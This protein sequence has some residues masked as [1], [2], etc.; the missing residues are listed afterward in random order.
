M[1]LPLRSGTHAARL[2]RPHK[3]GVRYQETDSG[4]IYYDNGTSWSLEKPSGLVVKTGDEGIGPSFGQAGGSNTLQNDDHLKFPVEAS[5]R[6]AF[7]LVLDWLTASNVSDLKVGWS[8]PTG[9]S[10]KWA[11]L[12]GVGGA[13]TTGSVQAVATSS[14]ALASGAGEF[15]LVLIGAVLVGGT[16]GTAQFQWAQN[17]ATVEDTKLLTGSYLKLERLA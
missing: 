6:W 13:V 5:E 15:F 12:A 10:V 2:A 3:I 4:L 1:T 7:Q 11:N 9:A 14:I 16:A 17:T 8:L